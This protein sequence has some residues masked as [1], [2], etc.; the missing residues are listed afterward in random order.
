VDF[1]YTDH[2]ISRLFR[3]VSMK[4]LALGIKKELVSF[5]LPPFFR[6]FANKMANLL[7]LGK[8]KK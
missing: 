7:R 6:N 1:N 5:V 8:K 4:L 2:V 3:P